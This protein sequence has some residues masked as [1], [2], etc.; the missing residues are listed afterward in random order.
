M[1]KPILGCL[2]ML[3]IA[4]NSGLPIKGEFPDI[5]LKNQDGK[6][7]TFSQLSGKVLVVSYIYTNCPDICH[8]VSARMNVFKERLKESGIQDKV[9]FVSITL[10]P[11]RDTPDILKTH[12]KMMNLDLNNWVFVTGDENAIDSTIKV[13]G[14]EAIKGP[15]EYSASG[16]VSYSIT[17]M[18]RISLVDERGRIR[19]H[20]K[21]SV[22]DMEELLKDIKSLL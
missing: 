17:H 22:F 21:G 6:E 11:K 2:L 12:A 19:K 16:E 5:P 7:F 15:I 8:M 20:Y 9:Y 14:M 18:D 4:C 10:D 13:A 1:K 3:F